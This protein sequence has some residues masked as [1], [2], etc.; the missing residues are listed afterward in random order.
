MLNDRSAEEDRNYD[1]NGGSYRTK[2]VRGRDK[3]GGKR[4]AQYNRKSSNDHHEL[5]PVGMSYGRATVKKRT[6]GAHR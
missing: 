2:A 6:A 4:L 1:I 3:E 5:L